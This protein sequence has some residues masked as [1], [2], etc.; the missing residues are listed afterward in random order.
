MTY[1]QKITAL[2]KWGYRLSQRDPRRNVGHIGSMMIHDPL[3]PDGYCLVGD[4]LPDMVNDAY[5]HLEPIQ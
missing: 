2:L 5:A 1:L 3:D 4:D